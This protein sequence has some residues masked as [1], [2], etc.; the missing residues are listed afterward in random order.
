MCWSSSAP[1]AGAPPPSYP[2]PYLDAHVLL[3]RIMFGDLEGMP[4]LLPL[5]EAT[6]ALHTS[7][8]HVL[9]IFQQ[10]T[11]CMHRRSFANYSEL[12][13][14]QLQCAFDSCNLPSGDRVSFAG[15]IE[16][17]HSCTLEPASLP[18]VATLCDAWLNRMRGQDSLVQRL[19]P[20]ATAVKELLPAPLSDAS[21]T[22]GVRPH[23]S[24]SGWMA[25]WRLWRAVANALHMSGILLP[26]LA[27]HV[28]RTL[29]ARAFG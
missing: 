7:S 2:Y 28:M 18:V 15:V 4:M 5:D 27:N 14:A 11:P 12:M 6:S 26:S 22:W 23:Q 10:A 9:D 29:H 3:S 13:P 17:S 1:C 8:S 20:V 19:H 16:L 25:T 21:Q 24:S